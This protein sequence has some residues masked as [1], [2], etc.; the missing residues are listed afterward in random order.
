M[1]NC[2]A[3]RCFDTQVKEIS[4]GHLLRL[5]ASHG[6][7]HR[8]SICSEHGLLLASTVYD[9]KARGKLIYTLLDEQGKTRSFAEPD[10]SLPTL[11]LSPEG[12]SFVSIVPYH[13][14]KELEVSIPIFER[15]DHNMPKGN[16]PFLGDFVGTL[17][18][19]SL[20]FEC[21]PWSDSKPDKLLYMAF[22]DGQLKKKKQVKIPLPRKNKRYV[23]ASG[24]HLFGRADEEGTWL[25]RLLDAEGQVLRQREL[26]SGRAFYREVVKLSFDAVSYLLAEEEGGSLLLECVQP[27]GRIES[28][29][30][31]S[32]GDFLYNTWPPVKVAE[33][34]YVIRFND[35]FGNGWLTINKGELL[36]LFYNKDKARGYR[37]L[38]TD[39]L[40]DFGQGQL[41]LA[42]IQ[43]SP[44]GYAAIFYPRTSE[45]QLAEE[46]LIFFH[47]TRFGSLPSDQSHD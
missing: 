41:I 10:G 46:L 2:K 22:K 25:H 24:L 36:E 42:D 23:D 17:G 29:P 28:K 4:S 8:G 14:D 1:E 31:Y 15:D 34:T 39:E 47:K 40:L 5:K 21:D 44:A 18:T 16:R 32:F 37:N 35:G 38:L 45:D 30:L 43:P 13:P 9:K 12:K 20:F 7:S 11:F 19:Y 6:V 33:E 27:D 26:H 3:I